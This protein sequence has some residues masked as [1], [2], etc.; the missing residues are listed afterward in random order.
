MLLIDD[1]DITNYL[2][3]NLVESMGIAQEVTILGGAEEGLAAIEDRCRQEDPQ[4]EIILLDINMPGMDGFD[5]L[6]AFEARQYPDCFKIFIVSSSHNS[7]DL[8]KAENYPICGYITK[9]LTEQKVLA[10]LSAASHQTASHS[11]CQ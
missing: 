7:R 4:S 8:Q 3:K 2:H 6:E 9:P 11:L 1:D 5:F 10:I